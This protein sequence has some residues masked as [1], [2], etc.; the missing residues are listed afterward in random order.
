MIDEEKF[1]WLY[2]NTEK[3]EFI[4][5]DLDDEHRVIVNVYMKD[6]RRYC[7]ITARKALED[8]SLDTII[9]FIIDKIERGTI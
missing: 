1:K 6:G 5:C 3:V 4:P 9:H 2:N 7:A 8:R